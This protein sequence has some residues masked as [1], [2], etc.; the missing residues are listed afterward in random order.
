MTVVTSFLQR[1]TVVT[2]RRTREIHKNTG[3]K[4]EGGQKTLVVN[5]S[6]HRVLQQREDSRSPSAPHKSATAVFLCNYVST[7][8]VKTWSVTGLYH[9]Y[10]QPVR[11]VTFFTHGKIIIQI[12]LFTQRKQMA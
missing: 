7:V 4:P 1:V 12:S 5:S 10:V 6:V 8:T 9:P 11:M 3:T 2:Q